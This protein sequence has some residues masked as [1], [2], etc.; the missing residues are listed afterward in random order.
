[1]TKTISPASLSEE[2]YAEL[3]S[4]VGH[5]AEVLE[6]DAWEDQEDELRAT[7]ALLALLVARRDWR[8]LS[9]AEDEYDILQGALEHHEEV[10]SDAVLTEDDPERWL[11]IY[12]TTRSLRAKIGA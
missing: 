12:Q 8:L 5:H 11:P 4:A 6:T 7:D 3:L 10:Y 1:M 9:L 2:E